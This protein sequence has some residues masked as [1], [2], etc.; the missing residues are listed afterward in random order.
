M[1]AIA[2]EVENIS[3]QN[4]EELLLNL[5][6]T[7]KKEKMV[8]DKK[9]LEKCIE[10]AKK[11]Y[12]ESKRH[13]GETT[14]SHSM[15]IANIIAN[16]KIGIES[17]YAGI[18][19]E[20]HKF[21][22][23]GYVEKE[24]IELFGTEVSSLVID[25]GKLTLLNYTGQEEIEAENL[26]K[27]FMALAKDVRVVI[28][29]LA[30]RLYNMRNVFEEPVEIQKLK[31]KES[32]EVY[33]PIAHRLGMSAIKSEIEDIS[34]EVLNKEAYEYI[35]KEV[36]H[37]KEKREEYINNQIKDIGEIL[38][39][40]KIEAKVYGR[41]KYYY[42]IYKKIN[43]Q[44]CNVND[45]FDL[46]AVRIIVNSVKDCYAVLG[47]I[48]EKYKPM[49][50]RFKDYIAVP[51]TNMYQSLHTAVFGKD[52]NSPF[53]V[54]IRTWDMHEVADYG[55][56][57]HFLY[58][59]G[60]KKMTAMDEQLIWLRKNIE[61]DQTMDKESE[62]YSNIKLELFGDEVFVFTP[63]GEIKS[64]PKGSTTIDFAYL[65][66]Q[67]IGDKMVGAKINSRIVPITTKLKNTD[68]VEIITSKSSKGPSLDWIK[69]IKTHSAKS[70]IISFLKK[71]NKEVNILRGQELFD[72][73]IAKIS[74]LKENS[75][76]EKYIA[77]M[78][79][80]YN[81]SKIDECY[82]NI[83]F[84]ALTAKKVIN[85]ILD[86]YRKDNV[87]IDNLIE[88]ET[89]AKIA[90]RNSKITSIDGI[91]VEGIDNCLIKLSNCCSPVPGDDIVGYISF[92]KGVAVHRSNCKH[93]SDLNLK[94]RKISVKWVEKQGITYTTNIKV[95]A[96]D[97]EGI[98]IDIL[99][100]LQ[101][102]KVNIT[103]F[104][105]RQ[106]DNRECVIDLVVTIS[107]IDEIQKIMRI[108]KKVDSVFDV[109]RDK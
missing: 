87:E 103:S 74:Y 26:R 21:K 51:K 105:S 33:A 53:E 104:K 55:V 68:I 46:Y 27:M 28:I 76:R 41:P 82:E 18:L 52:G 54:Q 109:R 35:K 40:E 91:E 85:K 15:K 69:S 101:E 44:K 100:Q 38:K 84:G 78:L 89:K 8:C 67:H 98:T 94:D 36:E 81:M 88:K 99:K 20:V 107:S 12:G 97:R 65:I 14:F 24:F 56:A 66:H 73:E 23:H 75:V 96:N 93:L 48:H 83:G 102:N 7:I 31:A 5:K 2:K 57:A 86:E 32:M 22:D 92:G 77:R 29:K 61:L 60:K 6:E 71:Q 42:S 30:D 39:K 47:M 17:V 95:R 19:H 16:L 59:E 64:L 43:I 50:G 37:T 106:T 25:S 58:K 10:Y 63:N 3:N 4:I 13:K 1:R 9:Y 80:R 62:T 45:L 49:P 79:K 72:K 11:V 34:F 108:I 70:K 90:A